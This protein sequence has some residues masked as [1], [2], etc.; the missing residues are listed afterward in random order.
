[1]QLHLLSVCESIQP[2]P[3][4]FVCIAILGA[5][6]T[7]STFRMSEKVFFNQTERCLHLHHL[8]DQAHAIRVHRTR[9]GTSEQQ[10][11]PWAGIQHQSFLR[12]M[13]H[14]KMR[15]DKDGSL[16]RENHMAQQSQQCGFPRAM[17]PRHGD[18]LALLCLNAD[19][20][21]NSFAM[22]GIADAIHPDGDQVRLVCS[23]CDLAIIGAAGSRILRL[24]QQ[25]VA[26][27]LGVFPALPIHFLPHQQVSFFVEIHCQLLHG[28]AK[29]LQI[30]D[31]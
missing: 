11:F 14:P 21:E 4:F 30:Q 22:V 3:G 28:R 20:G 16:L 17:W 24:S 29:F 23:S 25:G 8:Q 5:L 15:W 7:L 13:Q 6:F 12:H 26:F 27:L 2:S 1:M 9:I 18:Q 31:G 10:V 19:I